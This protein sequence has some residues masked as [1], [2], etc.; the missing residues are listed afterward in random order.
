MGDVKVGALFSDNMVLQQGMKCPVWGSAD[1]GETVTVTIAGHAVKAKADK[2]GEWRLKLTPMKA[3]GPHQMTIAGKNVITVKNVLVGE[4]WVCSGQS[5]MGITLKECM[6]YEQEIAATNYPEIRLF[7]VP[8]RQG[9]EPAK[10]VKAQW[11]VC[12]PKSMERFSALGYFFGRQLHNELKV[13]VG[14]IAGSCGS[15]KIEAWADVEGLKKAL[16][17]PMGRWEQDK[18]DAAADMSKYDEAVAAWEKAKSEGPDAGKNLKDP[19]D[20]KKKVARAPGWRPAGYW[21][22]TIAPIVPYGIK[23]AIWYQGESNADRPREYRK[24]MPALIE[25]WRGHWGEGDFPFLIVS[26][27]NWWDQYP[28][29]TESAWA[30]IREAQWMAA[31]KLPNCGLALTIDIGDLRNDHSPN[32]QEV[33]RRLALFALAKSYGKDVPYSGPEFTGLKMDG[34]KFRL[35]F[36]HADGGLVAKPEGELKGFA[37]AGADRKF[38]WAQAKIEKNTV[39]AWSDAV[40]K[41]VAVRYAWATNPVCN[42]YNGAGLPAVPFRTDDWQST[43]TGK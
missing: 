7:H 17:D 40:K 23:G 31:R 3:G 4:V 16:P 9:Y 28:N 24:L 34:N 19:E 29:P 11:R 30:E 13:P 41:P 25:S 33:G 35:S 42:L 5:N 43:A 10:D 21:N 36:S 15:T 8:Q 32:K 39:V 38:V 2:K 6:N 12:D 18:K 37:V 1:P 22:G 20:I 14:L 26:L 27:S